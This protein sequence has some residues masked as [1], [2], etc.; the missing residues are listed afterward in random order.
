[1]QVD[2]FWGYTLLFCLVIFNIDR[3]IFI[4]FNEFSLFR[5][6]Y[7]MAKIEIRGN[8]L[9]KVGWFSN[10]VVGHLDNDDKKASVEAARVGDEYV[11]PRDRLFYDHQVRVWLK[12]RREKR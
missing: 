4:C 8:N 7:K 11:S 5:G 3:T 10:K 9:V 2:S 1:M 12:N 6:A